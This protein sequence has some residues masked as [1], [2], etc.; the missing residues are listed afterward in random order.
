MTSMPGASR[1]RRPR[2]RFGAWEQRGHALLP[3]PAFLRRVAFNLSLGLAFI[4]VSLLAG[5]AG[6]AHFEGLGGVDSFLNAAMILAGMGP[7]A[8]MHTEAGKLFAG[9]YAL[10]SGL[11]VL[12]AAGLV[13]APILHRLLHHFHAD[14]KD[15]N[16]DNT[17]DA[18][19][20]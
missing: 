10:Y 16:P 8:E 4:G 5:M 11:A 6:Y 20:R 18:K 2:G 12:A 17:K 3:M 1:P 14:E 9:A 7:V 19:K 13:F 15:L